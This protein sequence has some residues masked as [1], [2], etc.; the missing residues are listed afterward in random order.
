MPDAQNIPDYVLLGDILDLE[1]LPCLYELQASV[2]AEL[3]LPYE[4]YFPQNMQA[5][6]QSG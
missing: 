4:N 3:E 5:L 6:K 1:L 2:L